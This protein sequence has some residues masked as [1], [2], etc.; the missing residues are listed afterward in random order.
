MVIRIV[1]GLTE[2]RK[3]QILRVDAAFFASCSVFFFIISY[4]C[5]YCFLSYVTNSDALFV[6]MRTV[7]KM[8]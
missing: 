3:K 1:A 8:Y 5:Y 7:W 6:L 2:A 4:Y